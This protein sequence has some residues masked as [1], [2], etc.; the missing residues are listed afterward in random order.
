MKA[1]R[2]NLTVKQRATEAEMERI[3]DIHSV[4]K[5]MNQIRRETFHYL[6]KF[7]HVLIYPTTKSGC[8]LPLFSIFPSKAI[9]DVIFICSFY[10]IFQLQRKIFN[11]SRLSNKHIVLSIFRNSEILNDPFVGEITG[12]PDVININ[13]L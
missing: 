12:I 10:P 11:S 7:I 8:S 5:D 1:I 13:M 2:Q 3:P 9:A 6:S 4:S